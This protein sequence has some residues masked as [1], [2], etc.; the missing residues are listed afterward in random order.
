MGANSHVF[1]DGGIADSVGCSGQASF[2][3]V[4][5]ATAVETGHVNAVQVIVHAAPRGA[6]L[7][8]SVF[9]IRPSIGQG[10]GRAREGMMDRRGEGRGGAD[11]NGPVGKRYTGQWTSL[12]YSCTIPLV[13]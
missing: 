1:S 3:T 4:A 6:R 5:G 9:L 10:K 7:V 8:L 11:M 2:A 13:N 12:Q